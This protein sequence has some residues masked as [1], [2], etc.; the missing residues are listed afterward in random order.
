MTQVYM[1][2]FD[3]L[4][5]RTLYE[6]LRLRSEVFI[7]EQNCVYQD[8]DGRDVEDTARHL[9]TCD[10]AG[11]VVGCLRVLEEGNHLARIGRVVVG[12]AAR[13]TGVADRL[14]WTAVQA[15]GER[16]SILSAQAHLEGFYARFGYRRSGA[17]FMEDRIPHA[18]MRRESG[19][20]TPP[21]GVTGARR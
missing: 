21:A 17:N 1:A 12:R 13:G 8:L 18:P 6:I 7:V 20:I 16:P 19:A 5:A 15:I 14:M 9:W 4:G 3:Q 10:D 11:Q 2:P